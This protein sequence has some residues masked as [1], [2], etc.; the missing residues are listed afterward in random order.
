MSDNIYK[1]PIDWDKGDNCFRVSDLPEVSDL[2]G[3]DLFLLTHSKDDY[4]NYDS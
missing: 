2:K 3:K 1:Q 4:G